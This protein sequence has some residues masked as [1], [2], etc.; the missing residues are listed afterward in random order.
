MTDP[1]S[2]PNFSPPAPASSAPAGGGQLQ[3][4][5]MAALQEEG[6][7]P[8]LDADGDVS[9]KVEGQQLF[10]R[11]V[12]GEPAMMRVFG[13]WQITDDLPQDITKQLLA[14]NDVSLSLNIVKTG[15]AN[16]NLIV[17]GEHL[18]SAAEDVKTLVQSTTQMVLTAVQLWHQAVTSDGPHAANSSEPPAVAQ[19]MADAAQADAA[20]DQQ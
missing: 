10:V 2:L 18:V 14:A 19:A 15:L 5:V 7:R 9:Y 12:D 20:G 3:E 4:R 11:C 13:Q 6:F 16:G 17:T 1:T 8:E